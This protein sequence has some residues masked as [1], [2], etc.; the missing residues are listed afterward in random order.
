MFN[1]RGPSC[2]QEDPSDPRGVVLNVK[3]RGRKSELEGEIL[4][5]APLCR[6]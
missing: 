4:N 5:G 6:H 3:V 1:S 2:F